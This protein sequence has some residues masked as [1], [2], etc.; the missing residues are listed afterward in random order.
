MNTTKSGV[1]NAADLHHRDADG[2][3]RQP[4]RVRVEERDGGGLTGNS[5]GLPT[6]AASGS[7]APGGRI[8]TWFLSR[9]GSPS[10]ASIG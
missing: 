9:S 1:V 10:Y 6:E 4:D 5:F 7:L 2:Q 8:F 3:R